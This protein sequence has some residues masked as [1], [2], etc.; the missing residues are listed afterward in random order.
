VPDL[1]KGEHGDPDLGSPPNRSRLR[2]VLIDMMMR[3]LAVFSLVASLSM[4]SVGTVEACSG[5]SCVTRT[6][7][8]HV[9][10]AA[11]VFSATVT[12]VRVDE[13]MLNGGR[14]TAKLRTDHV[15]KG[16]LNAEFEV[17]TKAQGSACG[18]EFVKGARYLMFASTQDSKLATTLCSGNMLLSAGDEPLRP[19]DKAQDMESLTPDLIAALGTPTRVNTTPPSAQNW[20]GLLLIAIVIGALVLTGIRWN[21]RRARAR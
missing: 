4:V 17:F 19:S 15:Y 11:A 9:S 13:P 5:C 8:Q 2:H 20:T 6:P 7:Q 3:I 10:A 18:Y 16:E 1:P 12:D 21:R 14:V